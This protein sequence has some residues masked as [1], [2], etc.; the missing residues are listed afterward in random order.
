MENETWKDIDDY[1]GLYQ[2]S[3]HGNVKSLERYVNN[4]GG[5]QIVKEKILKPQTDKDGY[6]MVS[7]NRKNK[8]TTKKIH[9]LVAIAFHGFKP[10][11]MEMVINHKDFI[12]SNNHYSNL[13]IVT[14]RTNSIHYHNQRLDT[15]SK[16]VGVRWNKRLK[17]WGSSIYIQGKNKD[18][19]LFDNEDA[20]HSAY[21]NALK[22]V[23][24]SKTI[25]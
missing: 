12:K 18:L 14:Q 20:A 10:C 21:Q 16:Y 23:E 15:S 19:G 13:E 24:L 9:Q 25:Y 1:V 4:N 2:I 6:L 5:R 8:S 17:K 22:E 11:G 7:L 3:S